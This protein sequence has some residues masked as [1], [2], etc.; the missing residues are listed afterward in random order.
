M[1]APSP[2]FATTPEPPYHAVIFT[3]LRRDTDPEGYARTAA[4]LETLAHDQ[5]GFLGIESVR[6]AS[7]LG[8]SVSYWA[9]EAAIFAWKRVADHRIAQRNGRERWYADYV[10]RVARVERAYIFTSSAT[11]G[12]ED[13]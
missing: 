1:S 10:L 3:S 7:G 12:L 8:I 6:D 2:H 5:P 9:S 4:L 13:A 11:A